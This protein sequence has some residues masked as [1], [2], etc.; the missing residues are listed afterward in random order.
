MAE[1]YS[2]E[3]QRDSGVCGSHS[4]ESCDN[5]C[6]GISTCATCIGLS[7]SQTMGGLRYSRY[8]EKSDEE[9][10]EDKSFAIQN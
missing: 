3:C 7:F 10:S 2:R 1:E 9:D 8:K 4:A 6:E 5:A